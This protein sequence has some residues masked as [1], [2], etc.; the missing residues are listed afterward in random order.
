MSAGCF[1]HARLDRRM[2]SECGM[3]SSGKPLMVPSRCGLNWFK[4]G[5]CE[6]PGS[7][8]PGVFL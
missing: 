1:K 5:V 7:F 4:V 3:E 6:E 2:D 8:A